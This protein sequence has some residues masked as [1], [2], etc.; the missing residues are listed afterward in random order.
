MDIRPI[1]A[2]E[3]HSHIHI[4]YILEVGIPLL[5]IERIK[6]DHPYK[7]FPTHI[8]KDQS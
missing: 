5:V 6:H 2:M 7:I 1:E 4:K 3:K 8:I